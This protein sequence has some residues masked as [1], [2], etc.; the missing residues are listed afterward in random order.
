MPEYELVLYEIKWLQ[1]QQP[2]AESIEQWGKHLG[3]NNLIH[4]LTYF[5]VF[6][7]MSSSSFSFPLAD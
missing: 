2:W 1:A 5:I 7:K 3:R 6:W 4:C